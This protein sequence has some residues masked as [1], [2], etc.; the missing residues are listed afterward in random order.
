PAAASR[1]GGRSWPPRRAEAS[2]RGRG[3]ATGAGRPRLTSGARPRR[4]PPLPLR[5]VA[6]SASA[7]LA[8]RLVYLLTGLVPG[9]DPLLLNLQVDLLA[10]HGDVPRRL[11]ADTDLLAHDRQHR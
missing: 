2:G 5:G 11:D 10:E 9:R 7:E 6:S 4:P 3:Q 8:Q 1:R